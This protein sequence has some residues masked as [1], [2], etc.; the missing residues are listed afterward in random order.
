MLPFHSLASQES[1]SEGK[2]T[3]KPYRVPPQDGEKKERR[4]YSQALTVETRQGGQGRA[5]LLQSVCA[6]RNANGA[7]SSW[8]AGCLVLQAAW[9]LA[10]EGIY[11][12]LTGGTRGEEGTTPL[13]A[14]KACTHSVRGGGVA[15]TGPG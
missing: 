1:N 7:Y 14:P 4:K 8:G 5:M 11:V 13:F 10:K 15:G 6:P 9:G 2:L 12:H 3:V